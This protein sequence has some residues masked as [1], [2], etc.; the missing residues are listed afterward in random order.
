MKCM[1]VGVVPIPGLA[2]L[3]F[4]GV[5]LYNNDWFGASVGAGLMVFDVMKLGKLLPILFLILNFI[6]TNKKWFSFATLSSSTGRSS[7][8]FKFK[9]HY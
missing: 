4:L 7:N 1:M 2:D 3:C 8:R 5:D 6:V 9:F